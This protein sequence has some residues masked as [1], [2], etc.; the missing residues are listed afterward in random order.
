MIADFDAANAGA[1]FL[2]YR[3]TLMTEYCRE[4]TFRVF[5]GERKCIGMANA[6]RDIAQHDFAVL[7]PVH[8]DFFYL[9]EACLLPR[10]QQHAFSFSGVPRGNYCCRAG[11]S[12]EC[13]CGGSVAA[14]S[15]SITA[16]QLSFIK[17]IKTISCVKPWFM[18]PVA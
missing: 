2:D 18:S 14:N 1:D 12:H 17:L 13:R 16:V 11:C 10:Q 4:N 5:A 3:A 8:I 9:Q 7:R 6:C 15:A